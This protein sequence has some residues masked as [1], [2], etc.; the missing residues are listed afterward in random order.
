MSKNHKDD[1]TVIVQIG[2]GKTV[3]MPNI[4]GKHPET[5][6]KELSLVDAVTDQSVEETDEPVGFN[7]YD[8]AVLYGK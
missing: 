1:E 2:P 4:Y 7:P 8:T 6:G 3:L 5:G